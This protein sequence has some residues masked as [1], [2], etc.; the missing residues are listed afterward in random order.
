MMPSRSP[1]FAAVAFTVILIT[2]PAVAQAQAQAQALPPEARIVISGEGSV[3]VAPDSAEIRAGVVTRA[4][5]AAEAA[6]ANAKQMGAVVAALTGAGIERT[7][8]QTAQFSLQPVYASPQ[9]GSEQKLTGFSAS[10]QVT[11][12][13]RQIGKA[14]DILDRLTAA[15][16]SDVGN[17]TFLHSHL[18]EELDQARRAAFADARRKAEL[19]ARAAGLNLGAVVWIT[20]EGDARPPMS[21]RTRTFGAALPSS[22]PILSGEDTLRAQVTVGFDV[23]R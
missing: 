10:N 15:G 13:V 9:P 21:M 12:K 22:T 14:G 7:D 3:S 5:T 1:S 19:Y 16:A 20:E 23:A 2:G 18:S 17:V 4:K 11:V 8:I 6:D